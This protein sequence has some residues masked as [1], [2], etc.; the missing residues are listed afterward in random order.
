MQTALTGSTASD[1]IWVMAGTHKPTTVGTD[2]A[3]TFQLKSGVA[4]YGGFA[5]TETARTER[6]PAI[7]VTVLSGDIDNNDSQTPII[8]NINTV[9]GN[10]TNTATVVTGSGTD[11]TAILDGFTV[12]GG[13]ANIY[14]YERGGGMFNASGHPILMN[15]TFSGNSAVS[16]GGGVYN[17]NSNIQLTN[18]TIGNN[19]AYDGGGMYNNTYQSNSYPLLTNVTFNGNIAGN[20]GG[21]IYNDNYGGSSPVFMSTSFSGNTAGNSGGA[22]LNVGSSPTLTTVIFSGNSAPHGG[23]M[24][25]R[26][27]SNPLLTDVTFSANTSFLY[28]GGMY[29]DQSSPVLT[30]VSF[31]NNSAANL[32]GGGMYNQY[33]SNPTLTNVIFNGNSAYMGGGM[34]NHSD[35]N[36]QLTSVTFSGNHADVD[37]GGIYNAFS[38]LT[39]TNSIFDQNYTINGDGGGIYA[40]GGTTTVTNSMLSGNDASNEGG[41]IFIGAST[42]SGEMTVTNST[43]QGNNAANNGGGITNNDGL[44]ITNS[45]LFGNTAGFNGGG[46]Y[47]SWQTVTIINSTLSGNS[48]NGVGGGI[49]NED[50]M[51]YSNTIVANSISGGDCSN[52]WTISTNTNNL[53]ED[54]SCGATLSSDPNLG[55][56]ASNGGGTQTMALLPGSPA[57]DAG[58]DATCAVTDQRGITRP[59]GAHCDIGA[60]EL[61]VNPAV[62]TII[63]ASANPTNLA[64]VDFMVTFSEPVTGVDTGD[65]S[66]MTTAGVSGAAVSGVSGSGSIYTVTVNTGS[67]DGTI[68][69]DVVDDNSIVDA[70]SN[71]LGGVALGDGNFITGEVYTINKSSIFADVPLSYWSHS[72]IERLYNAGITGGCS[73]IPLNYCPTNSVTRAQMAVFL[74]R[75]MHGVAFVPPTATGV[76]SDVPVGSF[77]ADFI[78]Q[79]A[80]DSITS[81]CGGGNFCPGASVTRAQMAI[82]LV[83]AMHGI[84]FV[85]PTA[86]GV[87]TDVPVGSFGADFIEQLAADSITSG[88]GAGIYCPSTTV[89][90]DSMAVFLVRAFNLP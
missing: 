25:N 88:C 48:A 38:N 62:K 27:G 2:R 86:T 63:R 76:F 87:F 75:G 10:S 1:E 89:K 45:T 82:F 47:N 17:Y 53:V 50:T 59:Q 32:Y 9:T 67:G 68:R 16:S 90:R 54:G 14:P 13:N 19:R 8:T 85:P 39:I 34:Y 69:L 78:E 31:N 15:I 42:P 56:L 65:F 74:V 7:N 37:G 18:V 21:G 41:A 66:L 61:D 28:G 46:L 57:I 52:L 3:A 44:T 71:Q 84:A 55:S 77:G 33:S 36:P 81:G 49:R 30:N 4:I 73:T 6:D 43:I 22:M 70:A 80:A 58:D 29:N 12:T 83:R 51:L 40:V 60:Y 26:Y 79:L 23:G 35:C 20:S 72:F 24:H 11:N 64:S 5:G